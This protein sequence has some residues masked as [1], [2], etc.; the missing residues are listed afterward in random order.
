MARPYSNDLRKRVVGSVEHDG[1]SCRQ[2]AAR[3]GVGA[4]TAIKWVSRW[5]STGDVG[6]GKMGGHRPK[7][8]AGRWRTWLLA[9]CRDGAFTLRGLVSELAK[10][11]LKVD[12]RVVWAFVH[13]EKLSHK[14]RPG[15]PASRTVTM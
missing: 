11:G 13:A 6:P 1:L 14:K 9:R 8:L 12:Y 5:R 2:A 7:K 10:Q 15:L 4:S 3:Y